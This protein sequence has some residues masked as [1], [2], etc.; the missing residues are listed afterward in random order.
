MHEGEDN[1][2]GGHGDAA[3]THVKTRRSSRRNRR[4]RESRGGCLRLPAAGYRRHGAHR[5]RVWQCVPDDQVCAIHVAVDQIV[6]QA[7][8]WTKLRSGMR[9]GR[10]CTSRRGERRV[11]GR[12][13]SVETSG[14]SLA[15]FDCAGR[16]LKTRFVGVPRRLA[17]RRARFAGKRGGSRSGPTMA[18]SGCALAR[19]SNDFV[20]TVERWAAS[21]ASLEVELVG[22]DAGLCQ[23]KLLFPRRRLRGLRLSWITACGCS[24]PPRIDLTFT[25]V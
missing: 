9:R 22:Q 19:R 1:G 24:L 11:L 6:S 4:R 10:I 14:R 5:S 21:A 20:R 3:R 17:R 15:T 8:A 13:C 7:P 23:R 2:A 18:R 12:V 16:Y 25:T